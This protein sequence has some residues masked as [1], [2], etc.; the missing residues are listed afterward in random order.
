MKISSYLIV[1][2]IDDFIFQV[3]NACLPATEVAMK[4]VA[5]SYNKYSKFNVNSH[6]HMLT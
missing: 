2:A 6:L 4:D 3:I 1:Y 5:D